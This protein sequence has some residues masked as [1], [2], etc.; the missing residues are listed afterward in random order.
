MSYFNYKDVSIFFGTGTN[1]STLPDVADKKTVYASSLQL[2]YTPN[3]SQQRF[4]GQTPD[5]TNFG[6]AGS[7]NAT[8]SFSAIVTGSGVNDFNPTDYTGD[9]GSIGATAVIGDLEDG[10]KMSGMFLTSYSFGVTPYQ[11]VAIQCDFA[12]FNPLTEANEGVRLT[13]ADNNPISV[14]FGKFGHGAYTTVGGLDANQGI[15]EQVGY[16]FSAQRQPVYQIGNYQMQDCHLVTAEHSISVSSPNITNLVPI[17]GKDYG[18]VS[19]NIKNSDSINTF[20]TITVDGR[21]TAQ[22][23]SASAGGLARGSVSISQPLK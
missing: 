12:I 3:I 2:N 4:L 15:A 7:P 18:A 20:P 8:L 14:D 23:L 10:I 16:Q 21:V 5:K 19:I 17:S 1:S 13:T 6:I 9:V 22:N 11:A